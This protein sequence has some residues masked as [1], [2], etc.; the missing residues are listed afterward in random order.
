MSDEL[1]AQLVKN[2]ANINITADNITQRSGGTTRTGKSGVDEGRVNATY[3]TQSA[4]SIHSSQHGPL[5]VG[6][7]RRQSTKREIE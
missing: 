4:H 1:K 7:R 3:D 6:D 2:N 5:K